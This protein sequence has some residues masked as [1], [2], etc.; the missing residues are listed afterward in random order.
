MRESIALSRIEGLDPG[1]E[2]AV[3]VL[4]DAGVETF[5]SCESGPGH[6]YSE[7][8]VRFYGDRSEGF[9]ALAQVLGK[10]DLRVT[11]L[12]RAW[13][14]GDGE[15]TGPYW[16]LVFGPTDRPACIP[17]SIAPQLPPLVAGGGRS[18]FG[19]LPKTIAGVL[20]LLPTDRSW[21]EG[22]Y[23]DWLA[24]FDMACR[25]HY[26]LPKKGNG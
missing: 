9:R 4:R 12:R 3:W 21:D 24:F 18:D 6:S 5:E 11:D 7:P 13:P 8:T 25:V 22:E 19:H 17:Y 10:H 23:S 1:I 2:A 15:P 26:R 16:E 14:I 20:E